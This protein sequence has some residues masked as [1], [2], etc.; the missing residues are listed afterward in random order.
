MSKRKPARARAKKSSKVKAPRPP[1]VPEA[2]DVNSFCRA[3]GI[4]RAHFYS[5][6]KKGEGPRIMKAGRRT[7]ISK[8]AAQDW[9][10]AME[11]HSR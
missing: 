9:R 1:Q 6:C 11:K 3:H 5:L 8:R 2:Y 4:S 7:L 10:R